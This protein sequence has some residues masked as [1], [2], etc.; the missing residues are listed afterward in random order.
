MLIVIDM[1]SQF[2][3]WQ[4]ALYGVLQ[5]I[6]DA[7]SRNEHVVLVE[8]GCPKG[9]R[10]KFCNFCSNTV[11]PVV[12]ALDGYR[13][14]HKVTK[15]RD[16]GAEELYQSGVLGL[17]AGPLYL[18][19]VNRCMCV[20]A[21]AYGLLLKGYDVEREWTATAC[22]CGRDENGCEMETKERWEHAIRDRATKGAVEAAN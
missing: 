17:A 14:Q 2:S 15:W 8:Y 6:E 1:Q 11:E 7:K 10:G 16:N 12:A 20:D 4:T 9:R 22:N 18:V 3:A 19:G 5:S 21:T 13:R